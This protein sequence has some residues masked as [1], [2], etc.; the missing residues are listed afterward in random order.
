V[1][2]VCG[3]YLK[4]MKAIPR[5]VLGSIFVIAFGLGIQSKV[6][7][8][9]V[10]VFFVVFFNAF[11]GVRE[12]DRNLLA[13][14]RILGANERQLSTAVILPSALSWIIASLHTSF[15]FALVGAIVG[16]YL[17]AVKGIGLMIATAQGT[18]NAN[19]V[20][21][22][23]LILAVVAVVAEAVVTWLENRLIRWRPNTVT[24]VGL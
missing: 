3:P 22:A 4:A 9:V 17:G 14:A 7:L 23:M 5:V 15:G 21:A 1:A 6:A 10:L 13:N 24:D 11:Q 18:F 8:A 12:V 19:G 20:F 16:E 2:D